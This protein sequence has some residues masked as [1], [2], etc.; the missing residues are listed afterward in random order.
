[1]QSLY[2]KTGGYLSAIFCFFLDVFFPKRCV[3]CGEPAVLFVCPNCV[4][5]IEGL[6]TPLCPTCGKIS[7]F[8]KYCSSCKLKEKP[9]LA[10]LITAARYEMGP[11]KE[12]VHHLKYS[13]IT[14]LAEPLSELIVKRLER[15]MPKGDLVVVPV[16]LHRKR[17][18]SRGFNQSELIARYMSERLNIPGGLA[19]KRVKNTPSQ[20]TLSGN[21][22][23]INLTGAFVC[24]DAELVQNKTV[25]LIDDVSTTGTTLNECAKI[26][27]ENGAK[28]VFGVVVARRIN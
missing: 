23:R 26:L 3:E 22:R 1:M 11:I 15:D 4:E 18:F 21:L 9:F 7:Q 24:E 14:A 25:L 27:R 6:K 20:V 16:P 10:G 19:L 2:Q 28:Q 12:M 17:E 8:S 5:N 13:G